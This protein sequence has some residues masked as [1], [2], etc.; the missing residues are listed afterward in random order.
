VK[1]LILFFDR[2]LKGNFFFLIAAVFI[3]FVASCDFE[4]ENYIKREDI[5]PITKFAIPDTAA[6]DDT[7]KLEATASA[8]NGCW[9]NLRFYFSKNSDTTNV[10]KAFGTFE[11][12]GTCPDQ[13]VS[14]D[15]TIDFSPVKTGPIL[16]YVIRNPYQ[17][18]VDTLMV[19]DS[20]SV[21]E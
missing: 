4:G 8:N 10:L 12:H 3:S 17:Y 18:S 11:S 9:K 16:F 2:L 6:I 1:P 7:V 5:V 19:L 13:V 21:G 20:M 15:T 14:K